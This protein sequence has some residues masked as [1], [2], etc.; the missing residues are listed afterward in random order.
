[1]RIDASI[2]FDA[3]FIDGEPPVSVVINGGIMGDVASVG[4]VLNRIGGLLVMP[5]GYHDMAEVKI[6]HFE[7]DHI[8]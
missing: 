2:E 7:L 1:M 4:M 5:P 6:P 3:V 8:S